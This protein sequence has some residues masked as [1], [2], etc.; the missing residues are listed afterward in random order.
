MANEKRLI[1]AIELANFF[2]FMRKMWSG[3]EIMNVIHEAETVAY[4]KGLEIN[5]ADRE[6]FADKADGWA[7]VLVDNCPLGGGKISGG[8][9]KNHYPK[10]LR[11]Q[12]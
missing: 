4:L 11:N 9:C 2:G 3:S 6:K 5:V 7:A 1:D 8:V 10:G 12:Q